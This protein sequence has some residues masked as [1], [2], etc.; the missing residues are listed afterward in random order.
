[1]THTGDLDDNTGWPKSTASQFVEVSGSACHVQQVGCGPDL[2]LIHGTAASTHSWAGVAS[3]L[4]SHFRLTAFDLP[5]HGASEPIRGN[6]MSLDGL[7]GRVAALLASLGIVPHCIVGHSAG[8]AIALRLVFDRAVRPHAIVS[9]NGAL[10]PFRGLSAIF[11]P[12]AAR[13]LAAFPQL[14][15]FIGTRAQQPGA[16]EQ[17]LSRMG[18]RP[19]ATSIAH[20]RSLLTRPRH[21]QAAIDM[22]AMWDLEPLKRQLPGLF[23]PI[24][25]I[26]CSEDSAVAPEEAWAVARLTP[27][28]KVH[29]LRHL[30]HLAHEERPDI[31]ADLVLSIWN[32][33]TGEGGQASALGHAP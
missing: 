29:Y 7:A 18:S 28:A 32:R 19:P 11:M 20:Y 2:V 9:I 1:M 31:L 13:L 6:E 30:G 27:S 26:A 4:Q 21:V 23:V 8:A 16:I 17:M 33:H 14:T 22:M 3:Q 24:D 5:G 15:R 25:L 10:M 12:P